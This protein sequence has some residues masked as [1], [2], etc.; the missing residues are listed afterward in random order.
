MRSLSGQGSAPRPQIMPPSAAEPRSELTDAEFGKLAERVRHLTGIVLPLH[1]R[2][3]VISRLRKR[4]RVLGIGEFGDYIKHLDSAAGAAE[5]GELI[6]VVTTNLT[7]FFRES[8]HFEDL[9]SVLAEAAGSGAK[10]RLRIWSAACSTGEE[11]YSIAMT[12]SGALGGTAGRDLRILATDLDTDVLARAAAGVY[13]PERVATCPPDFRRSCFEALPDGDFRI[14]RPIRAMITFNQ[15]N[16]HERWPLNG[17][18]DVIFCRNV[19]IYFDA[20]AKQSLVARFVDLLAPG[21]TLYLGHSESMLGNHPQLVNHG[22]TIFRK[23]A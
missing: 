16:L 6:N 19:L 20:T 18:L 15:L 17:P 9:K 11:P 5:T 14:T 10:R 12:T 2:Q 13:S 7:S 21:G 4:L 1:K 8:H 22:H 23:S 3:M